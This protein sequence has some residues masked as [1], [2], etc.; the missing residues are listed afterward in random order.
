M[1]TQFT[2][3]TE[4]EDLLQKSEFVINENKTGVFKLSLQNATLKLPACVC[5]CVGRE[6]GAK[7]KEGRGRDCKRKVDTS[8]SLS[9][10]SIWISAAAL[11]AI[12]ELWANKSNPKNQQKKNNN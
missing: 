3:R 1:V 4:A 12:S 8:W 5:V 9:F 7:R 6:R 11:K 10:L 2:P